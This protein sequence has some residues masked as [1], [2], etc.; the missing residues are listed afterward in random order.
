MAVEGSTY[1]P[2]TRDELLTSANASRAFNG[3]LFPAA[4]DLDEVDLSSASFTGCLFEQTV[5]QAVDFSDTTFKDCR[6]APMRL[7]SC[8]FTNARLET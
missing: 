8:K 4:L 7:T 5:L 1:R 6:F 2:T 3:I